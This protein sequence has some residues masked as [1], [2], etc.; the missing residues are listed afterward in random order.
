MAQEIRVVYKDSDKSVVGFIDSEI[1]YENEIQPTLEKDGL[2]VAT[3]ILSFE[4]DVVIINDLL[5]VNSE[6]VASIQENN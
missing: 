4:D 2:K 5:F 1:T 3:E 6:G